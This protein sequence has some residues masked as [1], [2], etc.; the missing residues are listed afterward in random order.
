MAQKPDP[1]DISTLAQSFRDKSGFVDFSEQLARPGVAVVFG[2]ISKCN[3]GKKERIEGDAGIGGAVV[4][5]SGTVFYKIE[6][7]AD[8]AIAEAFYG[9]V[10]GKT[11]PVTFEIQAF[12]TFDGKDNRQ[13]LTNPKHEFET[14]FTGLF[15]LEKE[16]GKKIYKITHVEKYKGGKEPDPNARKKASDTYGINRRKADLVVL[17]DNYSSAKDAKDRE[18]VAKRMQALLDN[19]PRWQ[20]VES[21]DRAAAVLA[22]YEKRARD[23]CAEVAK[24]EAGGGK[25]PE[26]PPF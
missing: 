1:G 26:K 20:M 18:A 6:M 22:P 10:K 24:A 4:M 9:D 14:P 3:E 25:A 19:K 8:I 12:K 5:Q 13:L 16:K 2:S 21:D 11:V 23:C 7:T 17:L 15:V